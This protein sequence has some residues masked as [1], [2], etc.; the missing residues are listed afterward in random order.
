M[1]M[2]YAII[3]LFGEHNKFYRENRLAYVVSSQERPENHPIYE[4]DTDL[5]SSIF[6]N[7]FHIEEDLPM[8]YERKEDK[9]FSKRQEALNKSI[10]L[11]EYGNC[12]FMDR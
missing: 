10:E 11:K 5:G 2:P 1:D 12:I 9:Y 7:D 4:V 3:P 6:Y 8:A